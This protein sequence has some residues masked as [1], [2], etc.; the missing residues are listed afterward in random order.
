MSTRIY[1]R[2]CQRQVRWH[3]PGRLERLLSRAEQPTRRPA[4][5]GLFNYPQRASTDC[6]GGSDPDNRDPG[7]G[8][9]VDAVARAEGDRVAGRDVAAVDRDAVVGAQID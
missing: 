8:A 9:E 6:S 1:L 3:L 5:R 7:P 4:R 2:R